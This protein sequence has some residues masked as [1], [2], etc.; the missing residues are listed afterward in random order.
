M[1]KKRRIHEP[2]NPYLLLA[3]KILL[4]LLIIFLLPK[5]VEGRDSPAMKRRKRIQ[6][7][8]HSLKNLCEQET[9]QHL[10]H[11]ESMN[12]VYQCVSE[13]CYDQVY[14]MAPL[15]PGEIDFERARSFEMCFRESYR[16]N[17]IKS[18]QQTMEASD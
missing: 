5:L 15:E 12:C 7:H 6:H 14:A 13:E 11:E 1:D 3:V 8:M 4:V 10:V 17:L 9:C 18:R 2:T 16:R